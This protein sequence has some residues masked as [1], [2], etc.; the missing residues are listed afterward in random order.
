MAQ[1]NVDQYVEMAYARVSTKSQSLER[2]EASIYEVIPDLKKITFIGNG[3]SNFIPTTNPTNK[4]SN[5]Q[6][7]NPFLLHSYYH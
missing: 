7:P 3:L 2:Q 1:S 4:K 6:P 5:K